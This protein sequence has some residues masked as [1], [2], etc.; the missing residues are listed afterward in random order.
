MNQIWDGRRIT[1]N[2]LA[3]LGARRSL[4]FAAVVM[5]ERGYAQLRGLR[6]RLRAGSWSLMP[7]RRGYAAPR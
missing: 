5:A 3:D 6:N 7:K 4:A 2:L 1:V